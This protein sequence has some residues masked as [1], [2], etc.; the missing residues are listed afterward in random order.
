[1]ASRRVDFPVPFSPAKKAMRE[2]IDISGSEAMVGTE[3]G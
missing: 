3:K 1:M 2:W